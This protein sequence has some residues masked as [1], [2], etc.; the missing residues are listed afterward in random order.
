M[1]LCEE[2]FSSIARSIFAEDIFK[3]HKFGP[4]ENL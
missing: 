4:T 3:K 1:S 2:V